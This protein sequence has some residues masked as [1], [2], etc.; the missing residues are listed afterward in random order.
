MQANHQDSLHVREALATDCQSL[1]EFN[2]KM[3]L[4]T[5]AKPL[6]R[7][8]LEAGIRAALGDA[9]RGRYFVA[10]RAGRSIGCL[11]LT[12]E[13][14]DWRN[15]W[16]WWIQSVFVEANQRRSGVFRKLYESVIER[17][18]ETD[19]VAGVRLYVDAENRVAQSVYEAL[20]M[21]QSHY[22][23]YELDFVLAAG[24]SE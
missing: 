13:W 14:S 17:A 4:E 22:L 20:G 19:D 7:E 15:G 24:E 5:E 6:D 16:F 9:K 8:L 11:M 3:A 2:A 10:E 18:R 21:S 1:V 23:M 12:L